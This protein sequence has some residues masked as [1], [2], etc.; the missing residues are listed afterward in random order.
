M[1]SSVSRI[2]CFFDGACPRNQFGRKGAMRAAFVMRDADTIAEVGDVDTPQGPVRS[3]NVAEYAGL[4]L[5]LTELRGQDANRGI[6]G[7][8]LVCGD[9]ELVI[10]Q[11]RGEYRVTA[12]HL[13]RLHAR[14]KELAADLDVEFRWIPRRQNRA[15]LLLEERSQSK[16]KATREN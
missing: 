7:R 15:G 8:Y 13:K 4:I 5:L 1:A 3:N 10:R 14:A 16:P 12:P 6:R 9:S 11:M 2:P